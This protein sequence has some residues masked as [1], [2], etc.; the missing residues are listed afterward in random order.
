MRK[1]TLVFA[2]VVAL[3]VAGLAVAKGLDDGTKSASAGR[4]NVHRGDG[5]QR[6]DQHVHDV[7]R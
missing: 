1:L 3:V 5:R 6:R 4:G 7:G 2:V